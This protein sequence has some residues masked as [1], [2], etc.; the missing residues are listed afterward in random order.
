MNK[1]KH[2]K[3]PEVVPNEIQNTNRA[4]TTHVA[5]VNEN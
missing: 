3:I 2:I 5:L 1:I 4:S